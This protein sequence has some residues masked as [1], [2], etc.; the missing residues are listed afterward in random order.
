MIATIIDIRKKH[1][2]WDLEEQFK[3]VDDT[4][5]AF[6]RGD[7]LIVLTNQND[8]ATQAQIPDLNYP[9]GTILCNILKEEDCVSVSKGNVQV[10]LL[11]GESKI[12][13]PQE[14]RAGISGDWVKWVLLGIGVCIIARVSISRMTHGGKV[15]MS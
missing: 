5:L 13:V 7:I 2:I 15:K 6:T 9:D 3:L 14:Q 12:Y 1:Q 4:I 11:N 8:I 10:V